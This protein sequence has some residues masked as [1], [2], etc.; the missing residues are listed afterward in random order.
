MP[1]EKF[2]SV[3]NAKRFLTAFNSIEYSLK[4]RYGF[5]RAMGFSELIRKTVVLNY[6]V[7]KYEDELVD[8]G[9]LRNAIIHNNNEDFVIAEPHESVVENIEHIEKLINK[10]PLV[11]DSVARQDV[12]TINA[13]ATM[14]EVVILMTKSKYSNIPVY[15]NDKLIGIANGQKIL[16]SFGQFMLSGGKADVFLSSVKIEDML[17]SLENN[18]YYFVAP[19]SLT[20]EEALKAFH[21]N[22]KLLA[23]LITKHGKATEMPLGIMTG[24]DV[25]EANAILESY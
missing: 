8:Y 15:D 3:S 14:K 25:I 22:A 4:T 7:R 20:I 23:I 11:L 13:S 10:P 21:D 9:R 6:T 12:L 24:K 18:D 19:S 1:K 17:S 5:N 16:D 2:M